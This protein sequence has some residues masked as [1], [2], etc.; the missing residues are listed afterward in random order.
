M[1][2]FGDNRV[3]GRKEE[4]FD[5]Q[6]PERHAPKGEGTR[7]DGTVIVNRVYKQPWV[8]EDGVKADPTSSVD[9]D[10]KDVG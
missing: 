6:T 7:P 2:T 5:V 9:G 10:G 8:A 3:R 1:A 4:P